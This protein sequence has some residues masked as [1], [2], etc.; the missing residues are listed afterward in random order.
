MPDKVYLND[1]QGRFTDSGL[2]LS[3]EVIAWGDLDGDGDVDVF[4]KAVGQGYRV[5]LNGGTGH[6][7]RGWEMADGQ[8]INGGIA[9]GDMDGDGDLDA[10]V[11]NGFRSEGSQPTRVLWNDGNG[12]FTDS[13]QELNP[14]KGAHL[15][16]GDLDG[17]GDLDVF[18]AN[19]DLPDEVWLN[20]G[21]G[22][23]LDSGLRLEGSP[24]SMSTKP[25]LGDLDGDGD[26]DVV[27]GSFEG[28]PE[29]WFN[30]TE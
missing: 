18:V 28:R 19:V 5:L 27:V 15:A 21:T 22:R 2:A 9:L 10:V 7:A 30:T 26:L 20:D 14:T 3:E 23:L 29:I 16:V 13:G 25:S 17:D 8:A 6:L 4:G 12:Q 1:G 11:A 24:G